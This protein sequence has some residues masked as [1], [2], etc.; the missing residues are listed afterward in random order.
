MRFARELKAGLTFPISSLFLS[1][2][3]PKGTSL[4]CLLRHALLSEKIDLYPFLFIFSEQ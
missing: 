4:A 3:A 2:H 1:Q